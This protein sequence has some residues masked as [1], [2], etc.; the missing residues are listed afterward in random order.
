[1]FLSDDEAP[2]KRRRRRRSHLPSALRK[3]PRS[4]HD[5]D[6]LPDMT[7]ES[8]FFLPLSLLMD[9][10]SIVFSASCVRSFGQEERNPQIEEEF[11]SSAGIQKQSQSER[12]KKTVLRRI[13][14]MQKRRR[15][16]NLLSLQKRNRLVIFFFFPPPYL[17]CT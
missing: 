12:G 6:W 7:V 5:V 16:R 15:R 9:A 14:I 8:C 13:V 2:R 10:A 17:S 4:K 1:M 11:F 3:T